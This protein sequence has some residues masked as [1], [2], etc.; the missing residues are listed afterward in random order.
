MGFLDSFAKS[1]GFSTDPVPPTPQPGNQ[2]DGTQGNGNMRF[3]APAPAQ[4]NQQGNQNPAGGNP[5]TVPAQ[6][7]TVDPLAIFGKM[8]DNTPST[9]APPAFTLDPA[10]LSTIANGQDF[11][12]GVDPELLTKANSGDSNAMMQ[13]MQQVSRNAYKAALSHNSRLTESFVGAREG[14]S[15]KSLGTKIRGELTVN[16]L[17]GTPNFQNPGVRAHLINLAKTIER[18]HPDASPEQIAEMARESVRQLAEAVNPTQAPAGN[19]RAKQPTD[20]DN[21]FDN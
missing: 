21:F 4:N 8:F 6:Q 2:G 17:T 11:T 16:A 14:F 19:P 12:Q 3:Q 5:P 15:S 1:V 9:D 18:E 7:A 10:Q 20:W 13:V